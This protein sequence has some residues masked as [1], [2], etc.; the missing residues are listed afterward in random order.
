MKD[1]TDEELE[2]LIYYAFVEVGWI[3]PTTVEEV[4]LA[5]K[6]LQ[7]DIPF[8]PISWEEL[9]ETLDEYI[10]GSNS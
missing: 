2:E 8:E 1:Y 4:E 5:E 6:T 3:I 9:M 7:N 10:S